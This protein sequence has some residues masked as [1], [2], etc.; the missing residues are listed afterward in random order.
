MDI[1]DAKIK[2]LEE[3]LK[4]S[5]QMESVWLKEIA[6]IIDQLALMA[7][8]EREGQGWMPCVEV[9]GNKLANS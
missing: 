4:A 1:K 2:L 5:R 6:L 3:Q 7:G 8:L 9:I